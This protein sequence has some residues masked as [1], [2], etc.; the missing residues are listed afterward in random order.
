MTVI[1]VHRN[2]AKL[3]P[4]GTNIA[5]GVVQVDNSWAFGQVLSVVMII[6]NLKEVVHFLLGG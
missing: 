2:T 5:H 4:N 3:L 6:A 1:Q